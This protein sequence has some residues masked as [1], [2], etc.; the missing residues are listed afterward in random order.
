MRIVFVR[1]GHPDYARDC[2]TDEGKIQA[3]IVAKRLADEGICEIYASSMGRARETAAPLSRDSGLPVTLLDFMREIR[4][5]SSSGKKIA[6]GG[7]PWLFMPG[8]IRSGGDVYNRNFEDMDA[9]QDND[10]LLA[11]IDK[12][13]SGIDAWLSERGFCREGDRYRVKSDENMDKTVA[14]FSHGG[15]ST[16][17]LSHFFNFPFPASIIMI[18]PYFTSV[19]VVRFEGEEGDLIIPKI[20]LLT[21]DRHLK[22]KGEV[23]INN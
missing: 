3:E 23:T 7:H 19:T 14:I 13:K 5:G 9:F 8:Y 18:R 17:V 16:V 15:S 20:E 11:C 12:V 21:D 22:V 1:H 10:I 4:W 6:E 2:L